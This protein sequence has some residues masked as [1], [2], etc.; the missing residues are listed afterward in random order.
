MRISRFALFLLV[1]LSLAACGKKGALYL[2]DEA[3]RQ[4][5]S[6]SHLIGPVAAP[7][8]STRSESGPAPELSPGAP[9]DTP[10]PTA[11]ATSPGATPFS[12]P[13]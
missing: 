8:A 1:P 7:T 11:P 9:A 5:S 10:P 2:P 4:Q 6:D 12:N 13:P 3:D